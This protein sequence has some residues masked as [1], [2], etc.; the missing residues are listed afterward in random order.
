M[1]NFEP[2]SGTS[3]RLLVSR[4]RCNLEHLDTLANGVS[5]LETSLL[6]WQL[7]VLEGELL[8]LLVFVL[9]SIVVVILEQGSRFNGLDDPVT[10]EHIALKVLILLHRVLEGC[11]LVGKALMHVADH[12]TMLL[13]E[14]F[15]VVFLLAGWQIE[16]HGGLAEDWKGLDKDSLCAHFLLL[17]NEFNTNQKREQN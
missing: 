12:S 1:L 3:W 5:E 7:L 2:K 17:T 14:K 6:A 10:C 11:N 4:S 15:H 13:N 9:E 8:G 16:G